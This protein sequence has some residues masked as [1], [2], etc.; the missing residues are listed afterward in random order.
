MIKL[1][2]LLGSDAQAFFGIAGIG[3][4]IATCSSTRSRNFTLGNRLSKGQKVDFIL[5]D[6]NDTAEGLYTAKTVY[7]LVR[8]YQLGAP[9]M[10]S[11]YKILY[12]DADLKETLHYLMTHEFD[13]DADFMI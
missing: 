4:L 3:D 2:K 8:H 7:A 13:S 1:S 5:K 10:E 11:V 6:M 9:I 12:E